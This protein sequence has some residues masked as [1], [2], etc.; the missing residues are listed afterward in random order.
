MPF[1]KLSVEIYEPSTQSSACLLSDS[2]C[3]QNRS[4]PK[5]R[6]RSGGL[7]D[8]AVLFAKIRNLVRIWIVSVKICK[9][10][11]PAAESRQG[12]ILFGVKNILGNL[13]NVSYFCR[14]KEGCCLG[15]C[16]GAAAAGGNGD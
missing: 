6:C 5:E 14:L 13:N 11:V 9:A 7:H 3:C 15:P 1:I 8:P 4:A 16:L 2:A 12:E 10:P